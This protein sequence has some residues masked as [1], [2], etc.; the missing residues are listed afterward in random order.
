MDWNRTVNV[1]SASGRSA[2]SS[3][4]RARKNQRGPFITCAGKD[5]RAQ[6]KAHDLKE[7]RT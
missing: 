3:G 2:T 7:K 5:D 4:D 1:F 6:T